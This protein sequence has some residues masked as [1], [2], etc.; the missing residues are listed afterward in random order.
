MR[1]RDRE[2]Q[3]SS[4]LSVYVIVLLSLQIFLLTVALDDLMGGGSALAWRTAIFSVILAGG[5]AAF[6]RWLRR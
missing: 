5:S 3:T 2:K 1:L 6:Y 4:A